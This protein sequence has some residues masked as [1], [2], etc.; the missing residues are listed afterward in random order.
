MGKY[1]RR[2]VDFSKYSVA[3]FNPHLFVGSG[4]S[5]CGCGA[6]ALSTLTGVPP[7]II[8]AKNGQRHYPDRFMRSF[9]RQRGFSV[10]PLTLCSVSV[11]NAGL[12][13]QHVL[14][15]SQLFKRNEA[16]WGLVFNSMYYH[17]FE[18]Y[19]LEAL[20]FL[21]KP[22]LTAYV[23]SHLKWR[24]IPQLPSRDRS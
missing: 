23:V 15:I 7:H 3:F 20:S 5:L 19:S 18:I 1:T 12:G 14:L 10:V 22:V 4:R 6:S 16:T 24:L 17:N 21:N 9:L 2:R 11:G 8:A 13:D